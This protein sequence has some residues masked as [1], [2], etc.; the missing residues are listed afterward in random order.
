MPDG[1]RWFQCQ[2]S[3]RTGIFSY[4]CV[5]FDFEVYR[6]DSLTPRRCKDLF[7]IRKKRRQGDLSQ[8]PV[9]EGLRLA[10][11][12]YD[13]PFADFE[14]AVAAGDE[15]EIRVGNRFAVN[16]YRSLADEAPCFAG[17][18]DEFELF[19]QLANP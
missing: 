18:R 13:T 14:Q 9:Q 6:P 10:V 7:T 16:P 4:Q 12:L 3:H 1:K 15:T 11:N 2:S 17:G 19:H 8:K 5:F